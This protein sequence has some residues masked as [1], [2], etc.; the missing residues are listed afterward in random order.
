[1]GI[2]RRF[3]L[4]V[5]G[6]APLFAQSAGA[7]DML[8]IKAGRLIVDATKPPIVGGSVLITNGMITSVGTDVT[9][10]AGARRIDLSAYTVM[11]SLID[12]HIHLGTVGPQSSFPLPPGEAAL[13]SAPGMKYALQSG[14]SAVR[15]VGCADF[16]DVA[17]Q[18]AI[19]DGTIP[20]PH[21]LPSGHALSVYAGHG[22]HYLFPYTMP[23][24][25]FYNPLNGFVSSP[26]DA[27]KAV[28]LQLKYGARAIKLLASG[29]VGS[30]LDLPSQQNLTFEEMQ[31]A[32]QQAHMRHAT[33]AAHAENLTSIMD[34]MRAGVDSIEHG[35][36]LNQEAVDYMKSHNIKF[37]PTVAVVDTFLESRPNALEVAKAKVKVLAKTH[38]P[39]FQ[40]AL[41]NGVFM[42]A[43]SDMAYKPGSETVYDEVII[44]VKYGMTP[45]QALESA[46]THAATLMGMDKLG[47]L[48]PGMEGDLVAVDGDPL[49]EIHI[50]KN[51]KLVVFKGKV[52][53]DRLNSPQSTAR[54]N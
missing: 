47:R 2:L 15:V 6:V 16:I 17:L 35:S 32:V 31:R 40:L 19:E 4:L 37:T 38:F 25:D 3:A 8:Y 5:C 7:P 41:K 49:S 23:M 54:L 27:E 10:P 45:Q 29:G 30:P 26:D 13:R 9:A 22:D 39:S 34:A 43:G 36:E 28:Q 44:E 21:I 53:T 20:G 46:T 48:A 42:E 11:P 52:V 24:P 50:I 33:V 12:A 51:L 14:V 1:M 18:N